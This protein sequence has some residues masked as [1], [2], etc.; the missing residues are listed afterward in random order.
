MENTKENVRTDQDEE[1]IR[2]KT[3]ETAR[4]IKEYRERLNKTQQQMADS[5]KMKIENYKKIEDGSNAMSI[6]SLRK[7]QKALDVSFDYILEGEIEPSDDL[8]HKINACDN[9]ECMK[10]LVK[11][12][13]KVSNV[14]FGEQ[15][16]SDLAAEKISYGNS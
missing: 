4:R 9:E 10:L 5:V 1:W 2:P 3:E 11:M 7:I 14:E 13:K 15:E 6:R 12:I 16:L 8:W